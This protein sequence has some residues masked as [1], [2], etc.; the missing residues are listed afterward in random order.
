MTPGADD[1]QTF[2]RPTRRIFISSSAD[3]KDAVNEALSIINIL[4]LSSHDAPKLEAYRWDIEEQASLTNRNYQEIINSAVRPS[5][6]DL[7]LCLFG[8][9]VGLPLPRDIILPPDFELPEC[10]AAPSAEIGPDQIPLT[11]TLFE[12]F[13]ALAASRRSGDRPRM[14]TF[15][16]GNPNSRNWGNRT[17]YRTLTSDADIAAYPQQ[18]KW[19]ERFYDGYFEKRKAPFLARPKLFFSSLQEFGGQL[20]R[21]LRLIFDLPMQP[22]E[23]GK[24]LEH[25]GQDD[26]HHFFGRA[27]YADRLM[28]DLRLRHRNGVPVVAVTGDSGVGKSS[29]LHAGILGARLTGGPHGLPHKDY[30]DLGPFLT[31]FLCPRDLESSDPVRS[32]AE[33]IAAR[34]SKSDSHDVR[35]L[36]GQGE[37]KIERAVR[38]ITNWLKQHETAGATTRPR[39][40]L[41]IDQLEQLLDDVATGELPAQWD[42]LFKLLLA[43]AKQNAAWVLL[44]LPGDR[45]DILKR[46]LGADAETIGFFDLGNPDPGSLND[47][48]D[49]SVARMPSHLRA[50]L[51]PE[52]VQELRR[53]AAD[54]ARVFR[55][56]PV[57]PFLSVIITRLLDELKDRTRQSRSLSSGSE[58]DIGQQPPQAPKTEEGFAVRA[59]G[60]VE[61]IASASHDRERSIGA[62]M[63]IRKLDSR[64]F[65]IESAINDLGEKAWRLAHET[66]GRDNQQIEALA[67]QLFRMLVNVVFGER[68]LAHCDQGLVDADA[69]K[70]VEPLKQHRLLVEVRS[71]RGPALQLTHE[72]LVD[73]WERM[74]DW[75]ERESPLL[76]LR[77]KFLDQAKEWSA[78]PD[79]SKSDYLIRIRSQLHTAVKM[80][81]CWDNDKNALP[82]EFRNL[83][84]QSLRCGPFGA[85]PDDHKTDVPWLWAATATGDEDLL[86][87]LLQKLDNRPTAQ[88]LIDAPAEGN[89][90]ALIEAA[91]QG[92][93]EGVRRLLALGANVKTRTAAGTSALYQAARWGN[94]TIAQMLIDAGADIDTPD[95]DNLTPLCIAIREGREEAAMMLLAQG[96][97]IDGLTEGGATLLHEAAHARC[98]RVARMLIDNGLDVNAR[99]TDERTSLHVAASRAGADMAQLLIK[100]GVAIDATM[101][102]GRTALH[103]AVMNDDADLVA[104][105]IETGATTDAKDQARNRPLHYAAHLGRTA[106]VRLL[107]DAGAVVDEPGGDGGTPL[108]HAA[109]GNH[110]ETVGLLL[111]RRAQIDART[112]TGLT[113]FYFA[114]MGGHGATAKRLAFRGADV[115]AAA[116]NG[117]RPIHEAAHRGD[118]A[119][120]DIIKLLLAQGEQIDASEP[121]GSSALHFAAKAGRKEMAAFLLERGAAADA[122]TQ[123]GQTPLHMAALAGHEPVVSLLCQR[124]ADRFAVD[125]E[126]WNA[127]HFAARGGHET[128]ISSLA[129]LHGFDIEAGDNLGRN[130]MH[131]AAQSGHLN[132]VKR[133]LERGMK[134]DTGTTS[135]ATVLHFAAAAGHVEMAR[136]LIEM[137][138]RPSEPRH[139]GLTSLHFAAESGHVEMATL[140]LDQGAA[141]EARSD[142]GLTPLYYA[143]IFGKTDV[144]NLLLDRHAAVNGVSIGGLTPLHEAVARGNI[145]LIKLLIGRGADLDARTEK[146]LT[147]LYYAALF[148]KTETAPILL[149]GGADVNGVAEGGITPLHEAIVKDNIALARV[150]VERNG[151]L[152]LARS[153]GFT[154]LHFAADGGKEDI[155]GLLIG[156]GATCDARDG[157]GITPLHLACRR[158]ATTLARRLLDCG[159]AVDVAD[160]HGAQPIHE[161]AD[162][163]EPALIDLLIERGASPAARKQ[164]GATPLYMTA[165][166]GREQAARLLLNHGVDVDAEL[167]S[168]ITPLHEAAYQGHDSIVALLLDN[169]ANIGRM[170]RDG[171]AA[172]HFAASND[173]KGAAGIL[174]DRGSPIDLSAAEGMTPLWLAA[175][176]GKTEMVRLLLDHGANPHR[177]FGPDGFNA[178]HV[179][180]ATGNRDMARLLL[181]HGADPWAR[182]RWFVTPLKLARQYGHE[183]VVRLLLEWR[184]T[185]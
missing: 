27:A 65:S 109:S 151:D 32:L 179:A 185:R 15:F 60:A 140:L 141:I 127:M 125:S 84:R 172:L 180:A 106:I 30:A 49:Q 155:A 139:D 128:I 6:A 126:G 61:T 144:A 36:I 2:R 156:Q 34:L 72:T 148:G 24:G 40:A 104:A 18:T 19:L 96:A 97:R 69:R 107:L 115:T 122:R 16:R 163:G 53:T 82:L 160:D 162:H 176:K 143:I 26:R 113:P 81:V 68:R 92:H 79:E 73:F 168:G 76:D 153:D 9:R 136:L 22:L 102:D 55:D 59:D 7:V 117:I 167:D 48:I 88:E 154:P 56:R 4:S 50:V 129:A 124:T 170:H 63:A 111:E 80:L 118:A 14:I 95:N 23:A 57:L 152:N 41:A 91:A 42:E 142:K 105:L 133:L 58:R 86:C 67:H 83:I 44:A 43:L 3:M 171:F 181:E 146:G 158:G 66:L 21:E 123:T 89:S 120:I 177:T 8:E 64:I 37:G 20:E 108:H 46:V 70:I 62:P 99:M 90:T 54:F 131:I 12:F 166:R 1:N 85:S 11:G 121:L 147:P 161:A 138:A 38:L 31:V 10:V 93:T 145:A 35:L 132:V 130:A 78:A 169:G 137:G 116:T 71:E 47:I 51:P 184:Q 13:D 39:L 173:R 112:G 178:L 119:A 183:A 77:A 134:I 157:R 159:V 114:V 101:N 164:N 135:G 149:D 5:E 110:E 165:L 28:H 175:K 74:R 182:A 25:F 17:Y 94:E 150:L 29:F 75:Y 174:L 33:R 87:A 100:N 52:S 98:L 103:L 45:K